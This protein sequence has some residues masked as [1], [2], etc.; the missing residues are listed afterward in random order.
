LH[1][2]DYRRIVRLIKTRLA[3]HFVKVD[4]FMTEDAALQTFEREGP[5]QQ[6]QQ[7][8][9]ISAFAALNFIEPPF[10]FY[11]KTLSVTIGRR[12]T[13][14]VASALLP[15][16]GVSP[17]LIPT[18]SAARSTSP[19]PCAAATPLEDVK[20]IIKREDIPEEIKFDLVKQELMPPLV[21]YEPPSI[22]VDVD[23]GPIKAVSRDHARVYYD[24]NMSSWALEV[25][26]RNG[27]VVSGRWL[28][29]GEVARL[30][31]R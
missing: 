24:Y 19:V 15:N 14:V 10:T 13:P 8:G 4:Q 30:G 16:T 18:V 5:D 17:R 28:A 20:P 1:R 2:V 25:R 23:L 21:H 3:S 29:K 11:L 9:Y 12:P 31:K 26:G 6:Q 7:G 27:A 22:H